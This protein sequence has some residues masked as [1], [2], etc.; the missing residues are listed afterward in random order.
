MLRGLFLTGN[1]PGYLRAELRGGQGETSVM[2]MEPLWWLPSKME[3]FRV[4]PVSAGIAEGLPEHRCR[5]PG[6]GCEEYVGV[7]GQR[8]MVLELAG[9][10]RSGDAAR[11]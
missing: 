5:R 9:D 7:E 1:M 6:P 10:V 2:D 8:R 11:V 4:S 3:L